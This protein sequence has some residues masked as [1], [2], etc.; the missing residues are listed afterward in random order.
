[1]SQPTRR[2]LAREAMLKAIDVRKRA[3]LDF[4]NPLD[5]Y[6]LC[7]TL[8]VS[9]RF[10][11]YSMEGLYIRGTPP[12][13]LISARRP[14]SRRNFTCGHELG[15][16]EFGHGSTIDEL[17][18][19]LR[20]GVT[21]MPEEF[22]AQTFAGFLL[23][24]T[25]GIR[26]AFATRGWAPTT[27]TPAQLFT[28][29]CSFG[30]GYTTIINHLAYGLEMLPQARAGK[31]LKVPLDRVRREALGAT[32]SAPLIVADRHWL[33]PALDAE[34]GTHLLLPMGT[35]AEGDQLAWRA[36]LPAGR[37]F[38]VTRPGVTRV[39][40][41]DLGWAAFVRASRYQYVGLSQY[42]HLEEANGD[43]EERSGD[44]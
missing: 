2:T 26:K 11:G 19:E 14:L 20:A 29:A 42:R 40:C 9:V 32:S 18:D 12:R 38:E 27:A 6:A 5:V 44:G 15:H 8:G 4:S 21:F 13:I 3:G 34:V 25:L 1:M 33:L 30:V 16:H 17:A 36:D 43:E 37:L 23:M 41:S 7:D 24:P 10:V 28:V 22:L 39:Q 35:K 31:L